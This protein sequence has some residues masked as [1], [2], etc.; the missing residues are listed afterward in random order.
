MSARIRWVAWLLFW[1]G[2]QYMGSV[3]ASVLSH[4]G[5]RPALFDLVTSIDFWV[6]SMLFLLPFAWLM[7]A[8]PPVFLA[9][10]LAWLPLITT[11]LVFVQERLHP[12]AAGRVTAWVIG[13]TVGLIAILCVIGS[14]LHVESSTRVISA[15]LL[16]GIIVSTWVYVA[17]GL[18]RIGMRRIRSARTGPALPP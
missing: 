11:A 3:Q 5:P 14:Q 13:G 6:P 9:V 7:A 2:L 16:G 15:V 8:P 17:I 4:F 18:V 1:F 12:R 10:H